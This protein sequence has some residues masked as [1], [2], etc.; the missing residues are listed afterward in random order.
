MDT[1]NPIFAAGGLLLGAAANR[2]KIAVVRRRRYPGELALPKGKLRPGEEAIEAAVREVRE[3][4]GYESM[5]REYAGS[6]HYLVS[7]APKTVA[8][9]LM[10]AKGMDPVGPTDT[11][12]IEAVDWMTPKEALTVLTHREDRDLVARFFGI[13][14]NGT[15]MTLHG[16]ARKLLCWALGSPERDR[17]AGEIE[18]ARIEYEA[19]SASRADPKPNWAIAADELLRNADGY[20]ASYDLERS[21][22]A[23]LPAKRAILLGSCDKDKIERIAIALRREADDKITGWRAKVLK[24]LICGDD[25]RLLSG[26]ADEVNRMRVIEALAIRDEQ[27]LNN[28]FKI[29]LRRHHLRH[30]F[31]MLFISIALCFLLAGLGK[32]SLQLP[33]N[34]GNIG[35]LAMVVAFGML[36][37]SVSVAQ[38][39]LKADIADK[40]PIQKMNSFVIWMRPGIGAAAAIVALILY[41]SQTPQFNG[42]A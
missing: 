35:Q 27:Y 9:Y 28:S 24:G 42:T 36:G 12:E 15:V 30:A 7:G 32:L 16:R 41:A 4:T 6:T 10:E 5:V 40:I 31:M 17:L 20:L 33:V 3:E 26:L 19:N 34:I 1:P 21:W 13:N 18:N 39:L 38:S 25:G 8:Y 23:L 37:A 11:G 29:L 2:G 22:I 14:A